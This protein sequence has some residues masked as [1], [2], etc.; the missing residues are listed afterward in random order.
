MPLV[1]RWLLRPDLL[2]SR[3]LTASYSSVI[4]TVRAKDDADDIRRKGLW[5][6]GRHHKADRFIQSGPDAFCDICCGWG[7]GAHRCEQ[8]NKPSCML[9]G[10]G[11]QT[12]N[13][14]CL[15]KGCRVERGTT[16]EHLKRK[17]SNCGRAHSAKSNDCP[18]KK[19]ALK[20]ARERFQR[21][22]EDKGNSTPIDREAAIE[23]APQSEELE[24]ELETEMEIEPTPT[25]EATETGTPPI[26]N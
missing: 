14:Q 2:Q 1:P 11:H 18:K 7:H 15:H 19:E 20:A 9:C 10:E 12:K 16:C 23:Q 24:M 13:H 26:P 25:I 17:C 8:P 3:S 6:Y 21:R 5:I 4:I 22:K